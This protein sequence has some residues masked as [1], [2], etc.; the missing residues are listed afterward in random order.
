[1][2]EKYALRIDSPHVEGAEYAEG[3]SA[4]IYTNADPDRYVEL[5]TYGPLTTMKTGDKIERTN[6]YTLSRRTD[7]DPDRQARKILY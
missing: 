4:V 3:S 6:V 1:M 7:S 5:E 2:N